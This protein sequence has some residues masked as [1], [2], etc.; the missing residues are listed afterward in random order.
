[1]CCGLFYLTR[2]KEAAVKEEEIER[3]VFVEL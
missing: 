2:L 3:D 1:M